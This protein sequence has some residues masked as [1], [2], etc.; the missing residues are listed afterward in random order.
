MKSIRKLPIIIA[1]GWLAFAKP[2]A[3]GPEFALPVDCTPGKTCW[4]LN[5]VDHLPEDGTGTDAMCGP[6]T[7]DGHKGTDI[8]IRSKKEMDE[9]VNVLAAMEG[10]VKLI[11]DGEED[12]FPGKDDLK[13]VK[14]AHKECGNAVLID[15]GNALE[16]IY[17]HLKKDSVTVKRGDKVVT[18]QPIG[19]VG[20][21]GYTQFPH[22]HF[23]ILW[24]G[25][26]VDPFT[27]TNN[28][29]ACGTVK[30]SLWKKDAGI[31]FQETAIYDAGFLAA[32]PDLG[33]IDEGKQ[34]AI[35]TAESSIPLL[36]FYFSYLGAQ[37]GDKITI[38]ISD[39][40]GRTLAAHQA[41]QPE[42]H[43]RQYYYAG[44]KLS[45][46]PLK[47]GIYRAT[48]TVMRAKDGN[49]PQTWTVEKSLTIK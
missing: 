43:A 37:E 42:T 30:T 46:T 16:T 41:T 39:P 36:T 23:G 48:A 35:D 45:Q 10:T 21:S 13:A 1:I 11:R 28:T 4:P 6:R 12:R 29:D 47:P 5:Y 15:H 3:A 22:V 14:D 31:S 8:A 7:Y 19:Q 17:C 40:E 34:I 2:A 18:G 38:K 24:E 44:R 33:Q 25:A 26:I 20:L 27:G 32:V 9:G 49:E